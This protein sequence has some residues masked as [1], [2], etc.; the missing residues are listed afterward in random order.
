MPVAAERFN[1]LTDTSQPAHVRALQVVELAASVQAVT[2]HWSV[3][4]AYARHFSGMYVGR[5]RDSLHVLSVV[6]HAKPPADADIENDP[7]RLYELNVQAHVVEREVP[8]RVGAV[9]HVTGV[10]WWD[11]RHCGNSHE[12]HSYGGSVPQ[13]IVPEQSAMDRSSAHQSYLSL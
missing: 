9:V 5:Y 6:L 1:A 12:F 7:Q 4:L 13:V 11:G 10:A 3:D 2:P 8:L